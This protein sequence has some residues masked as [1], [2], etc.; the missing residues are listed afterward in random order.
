MDDPNLIW[1]SENPIIPKENV[2]FPYFQEAN[3]QHYPVETNNS[4]WPFR[5]DVDEL[6]SVVFDKHHQH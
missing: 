5:G 1:S 2:S 3:S 6:G 4:Q